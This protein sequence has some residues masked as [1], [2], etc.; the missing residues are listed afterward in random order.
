MKNVYEDKP[1]LYFSDNNLFWCSSD[2]R[3]V[4]VGYAV[5]ALIIE[6]NSI[7]LHLRQLFQI[8]KVPKYSIIYRTNSLMSL[9]KFLLITF[10]LTYSME[11]AWNISVFVHTI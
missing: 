3:G 7:F 9:G 4:Y 8:I 1:S 11:Q 10:C 5:V 2:K 6:L